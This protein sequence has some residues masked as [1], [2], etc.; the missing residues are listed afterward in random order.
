MKIPAKIAPLFAATCL[1]FVPLSRAQLVTYETET[2]SFWSGSVQNFT[3]TLGDEGT[4][5]QTFSNIAQIN[6]LTYA[7]LSA[8]P[9]PAS[10]TL[11]YEF[12]QWN[13]SSFTSNLGT[14][15]ITLNSAD[16]SNDI[17]RGPNTYHAAY[18]TFDASHNLDLSQLSLDPDSTYALL[19]TS[20]VDQGFGL[21]TLGGNKFPYGTAYDSGGNLNPLPTSPTD[22]AFS[23]ISVEVPPVIPEASTVASIIAAIFIAGLVGFRLRQRRLQ[24]LAPVPVA[25][26]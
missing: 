7:F 26:A 10:G 25:S 17:V 9:S 14:G 13:G 18:V 20:T 19:F 21:G 12:G 1:A 5:G 6:S 22:Y 8:S 23:Y 15:S 3:P 24:Q 16:F 4:L 11:S 2:L